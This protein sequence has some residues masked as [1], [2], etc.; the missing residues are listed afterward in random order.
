MC[1]DDNIGNLCIVVTGL[2]GSGK[3]TI[4]RKVAEYLDMKFL[5]KD[6]YL[7]S[8]F[9]ERGIG[10]RD[11]RQKISRESDELFRRDAESQRV[12]VLV[13]HWRTDSGITNTGT[14]V[15]WIMQQFT[16]TIELYCKC[17]V[18]VA[19]K[20]FINRLRH[21]GHLDEMKTP[22]QIHEWMSEY[23]KHLPLSLGRLISYKSDSSESLKNLVGRLS[24]NIDSDA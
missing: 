16:N 1:L 2:P 24:D 8:L 4:G 5:D 9:E 17:P 14:P 3:T 18:E 23:Q 15:K 12:A 21:P 19:E 7:E 11:W 10:N 13:S 22:R 20:R 6:D